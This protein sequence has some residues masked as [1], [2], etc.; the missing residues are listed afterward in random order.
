MEDLI[1]LLC[2]C[3]GTPCRKVLVCA[4][5][6]WEE[7]RA[8]GAP[9]ALVQPLEFDIRELTCAAVIIAPGYATGRWKLILHDRCRAT[10]GR[11]LLGLVIVSHRDCTV[12]G[13]SGQRPE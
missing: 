3:S 12:L 2:A 8:A 1:D 13:E 5:D 6:V 11:T 10:G 4:R 7:M 9:A